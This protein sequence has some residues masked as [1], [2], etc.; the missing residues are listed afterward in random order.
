MIRQRNWSSTS[1]TSLPLACQ[2]T[3]Q[4]S[5]RKQSLE[6]LAVAAEQRDGVVLYVRSHLAVLRFG[7]QGKPKE[8]HH[9]Y[10]FA[11]SLLQNTSSFLTT[12]DALA[13]PP[14]RAFYA[15]PF[16]KCCPDFLPEYGASMIAT[17]ISASPVLP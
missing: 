9:S 3:Y 13:L 6:W 7:L 12:R 8:G 4:A 16:L 14:R 2:T 1:Q 11:N 17:A 15:V 5:C 10:S